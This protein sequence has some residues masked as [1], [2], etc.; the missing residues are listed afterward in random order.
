MIYAEF[1]ENLYTGNETID[2]QHKELIEKINR[3]LEVC[4]RGDG[5][6]AALRMLNF[7]SEYTQFHFREEEQLQQEAGYPGIEQHRE[8]HE[9]LRRTVDELYEMLEEE[10]GPTDQFV[11]QVSLNVIEWLY[12][13][14]QGF[15]RSVAEYINI[16]NNPELL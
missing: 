4:E 14:I 1:G 3:L 16:R 2:T 5:R 12:N 7:L 10:E 6:I 11:H 8:K 13:H 15:D 9:E